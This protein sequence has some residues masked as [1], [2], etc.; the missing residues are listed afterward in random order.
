VEGGVDLLIVETQQDI[1]EVK[2][3][4]Y[5][6]NRYFEQ[7]GV[8]IPLQ[9]QVTLDTTGR[10][11][12]GTDIAAVLAILEALPVDVVGMG[13]GVRLV[14]EPLPEFRTQIGLGVYN[15]AGVA[16]ATIS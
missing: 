4:I 15:T 1:L 2:A 16:Q 13:S 9:V 3:A 10:M 6:I 5:G 11:L 8:R 12:L 7:A 14:G